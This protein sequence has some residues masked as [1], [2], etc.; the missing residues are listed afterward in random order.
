MVLFCCKFLYHLPSLKI[1][2]LPNSLISAVKTTIK[3]VAH[4]LC[5][6]NICV[7]SAHSRRL[8]CIIIKIGCC[9]QQKIICEKNCKSITAINWGSENGINI[10]FYICTITCTISCTP[11]FL[12]MCMGAYDY[13]C[14]CL[15]GRSD[16]GLLVY[17]S[18]A[19][20]HSQNKIMSFL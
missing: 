20:T 2:S 1:M 18:W 7:L 5:M 16:V 8:L 14:T 9:V 6:K 4:F 3:T 15:M 13:R 11:N 10:I 19:F 12:C 17:I